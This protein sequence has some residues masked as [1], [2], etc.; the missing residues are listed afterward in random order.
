MF[1][2]HRGG[3]GAVSADK[4]GFVVDL[5]AV[6]AFGTD[7]QSDLDGHLSPENDR[8]LR[9]FVDTPI[10]GARTASPAVQMAAQTYHRQLIAM[11]G[12][13]DTFLHNGAILA[14]V[15][16]EVANAYAEADEFSAVSF[17][18]VLE[19]AEATVTAAATAAHRAAI[20]PKTGKPV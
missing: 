13:V 9:A 2:A 15:A 11:L 6:R 16:E 19:T 18:G 10:F 17:Q 3:E 14:Q 8:I 1:Y 20:D 5:G 4:S 7:L 12:L